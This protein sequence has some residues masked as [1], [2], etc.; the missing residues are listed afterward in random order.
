[1]KLLRKTYPYTE[2]EA[3]ALLKKNF[4]DITKEEF[5]E[6]IR[7]GKIDWMYI[8][9]EKR[10]ERRFDSNLAFSSKTYKA[11]QKATKVSRES[12]KRRKVINDAIARLL[13]GGKP[14]TYNVRAKVTMKRENPEINALESGSLSLKKLFSNHP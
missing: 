12:S 8:E 5:Q 7:D 3:F 1:M 9:D 14:K 6:L 4:K 11:R 2:K 13:K 10:F